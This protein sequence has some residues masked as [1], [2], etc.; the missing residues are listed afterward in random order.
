M[1]DLLELLKFLDEKLGEFTI[2]TDRN[3]VEEDDLSLFIT[4]GKEECLEFEDLKKISEFC[5]DL[6]VNTDD[7]GK[8]FLQLLFLPKKGGERK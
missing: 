6:T 3:Y 5:D 8:L 4:L 1:K 2:T 7:E